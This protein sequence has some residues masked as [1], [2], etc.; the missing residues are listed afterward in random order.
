M[1]NIFFKYKILTADRMLIEFCF[2]IGFI[3]VFEFRIHFWIINT[4]VLHLSPMKN[5]IPLY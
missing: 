1:E 2:A 5:K 4:I 3:I